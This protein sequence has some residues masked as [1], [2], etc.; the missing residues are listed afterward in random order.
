MIITKNTTAR[1]KT[2]RSNR[3][4]FQCTSGV[5]AVEFALVGP[6]FLAL[7]FSLFETGLLYTKIALTD[8]A[9][10]DISRTIYVGAAQSDATITSDTLKEDICDSVFIIQDCLNNI[11]IE[12]TTISDFDSI[13]TDGEICQDS[14]DSAP[15]PATTYSPGASSQISFVRVCLTTKIITPFLGLGLKLTKNANN[16]FEI[17]SSL[18][19]VNEPF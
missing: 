8:N 17:I 10:A 16:R 12:V 4:L 18:A 13:P 14:F 2:V 6:I 11:T 9:I 19:F 5:A 3:N 15:P 1:I 7:V